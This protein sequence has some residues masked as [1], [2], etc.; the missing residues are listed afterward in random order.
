M[1]NFYTK[2]VLI[3]FGPSSPKPARTKKKTGGSEGT[4]GDGFQKYNVVV[5]QGFSFKLYLWF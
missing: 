4:T 5:H 3:S 1:I 2:S